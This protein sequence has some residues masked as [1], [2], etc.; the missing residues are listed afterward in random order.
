MNKKWKSI[1]FSLLVRIILIF[2]SALVILPLLWN[3]ITS[4]KSNTEIMENPWT[5]PKV[6]HFENYVNA[7]VKANM[8]A[9]AGNSILITLFSLLILVFISVCSS[10]ALARFHFK[11][12]KPIKNFFMSGIFIQP[13]YIMIPLFLL[14]TK[15]QMND[16]R[17]W[18]SVVYAVTMLPFSIFLLYGFFK[19]IPTDYEDAAMIDGCGYMR[20]MF[21]IV[22]PLARPG[23]IFGFFAFWNEYPLALVL[24]NTD[25]KKTLP[26][27]LQNL[28]EVQKYA[29]DWGAL[30]AGL[31]ILLVPTLV[32]YSLCQKQ[33]TQ[34]MQ[35]GGIKG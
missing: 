26:I 4:F 18:I 20:T 25:S 24:L 33:L 12:R 8:G 5:L 1:L 3:I 19:S 2:S 30:F 14:M 11:L 22:T 10:Y 27:G 16:N 15:L 7:V 23:M 32:I 17:G 35:V 21:S 29:T 34:G 28:M 31:V 13:V 9:Y 6:L